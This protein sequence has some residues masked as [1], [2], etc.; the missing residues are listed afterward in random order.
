MDYILKTIPVKL[1]KRNIRTEAKQMRFSPL[2]CFQDL[3]GDNAK[4]NLKQI[5]D[6]LLT[7][8]DIALFKRGEFQEKLLESTPRLSEHILGTFDTINDI[9]SN[10]KNL[11]LCETEFVNL[12]TLNKNISSEINII[13]SEILKDIGWESI[14]KNAWVPEVSSIYPIDIPNIEF[15]PNLD[16]LVIDCPARNL[17]FLP[18]GLAYLHNAL[19]KTSINFQTFDLDIITYHRYHIHRLLD[20]PEKILTPSGTEMHPDPW[21]AEAYDQWQKPEV[22]E[23]FRPIIEE[24]ANKIVEAKPKVLGLSLQECNIRFARELVRSVKPRLPD[25]IILVGGFACYQPTIG[26]RAFPEC[27]YMCIGEADL[28]IGPLVEALAR[29]ERPKD[30][31]GVLSRFDSPGYSFTN[32]PMPVDLDSIEMA[33]YDWTDIKLYKN[34]NNY[35]LTPIIASRG[36][37]WSRCTF[38][39]ERFYWRV[40]DPKLVVDEFEY[41]FNNGCELFMFNESDLNGLPEKVIAICDE[42][43]KRKLKIRLTGQLRIHKK[44]NRAYFD[45]LVEAGFVALRFGVDAWSKNT[46]KLQMKGY[47]LDMIEQNLRD[48]HKAGIYTEVNTVIGSPGETETDIDETIDMMIKCEPYVGRH[49]NMNTLILAIGSVYWEDPERYKIK[50]HKYTQE[51]I[52]E[53]YPS[54]IPSDL[55]H[56]EEPFIDQNVR[57]QRYKRV[58]E[59]L[60]KNNV[61][62]GPYLKE[63]FDHV[64]SQ[65]GK[66]YNEE[67]CKKHMESLDGGSDSWKKKRREDFAYKV[68]SKL[69]TDILPEQN[70]PLRVVQYDN[71]FWGVDENNLEQYSQ[72]AHYT[73]KIRLLTKIIK[74]RG[75]PLLFNYP[76]LKRHTRRALNIISTD[77]SAALVNKIKR[78]LQQH[79][80]SRSS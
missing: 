51:E 59:T 75:L 37:R 55:W 27:D 39:A 74:D 20:R 31:P 60:H 41:L 48:C 5:G 47:T 57:I 49:A 25:T 26:R 14:P 3:S 32:Y 12:L 22:I 63:V 54:F 4:I 70:T 33:T 15:L 13:T 50:F 29:G 6:Y 45:K 43:I 30:L 71:K 67:D 34:Y 73:K 66:E 9:S 1:K 40:R 52:F 62:M 79:I 69:N 64:A 35:Q 8:Q 46:L 21:L 72:F 11:F 77:G 19:K 38:C 23:Y 17:A 78:K 10:T 56:S 53:K 18:N 2:R 16:L 36:C 42:I 65:K 7:K 80:N 28:T 58:I 24:A 76:K 44:S 68:S 61:D